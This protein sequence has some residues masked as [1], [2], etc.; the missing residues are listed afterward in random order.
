MM[1]LV[2]ANFAVVMEINLPSQRFLAKIHIMA[3]EKKVPDEDYREILSSEFGVRSSKD[4]DDRQ[5]LVFIRSLR[6]FHK[7][8]YASSDE[9]R[10]KIN[11]M[12][13]E[14]HYNHCNCGDTTGHKR[15]FL[16][17]RFKVSEV[18]FLDRRKAYEAVEALKSMTKKEGT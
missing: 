18:N 10:W 7:D 12:W 3:K 14:Y 9:I 15:R 4:L 13:N 6:D 1:A 11:Q 8:S 2:C 5:A 17:S 16:F